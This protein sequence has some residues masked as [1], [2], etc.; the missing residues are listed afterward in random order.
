D[1]LLMN[2]KWILVFLVTCLLSCK[3][4]HQGTMLP[5]ASGVPI[6][7]T[8]DQNHPGNIIPE[9]FAG[10][11]YE[12]GILAESPEILN[13]NNKVL[14]QLIKNLGPGLLRIGGDSSD[15]TEWTGHERTSATGKDDLTT[16]DIDRLS[17]FSR[18]T[19]WPVLFGLNLGNNN[20]GAA[21]DEARY[22]YKALQNN[23]YALVLGNEPDVYHLFGLRTPAYGPDNFHGDWE[24]YRS[25][26]QSLVPRAAFAGPGTAY[27]TDWITAFA[28]NE[29]NN[30]IKL[31]DAHYY[32]T[33]PA[34][35]AT[36]THSTLLTSNWKLGNI[37]HVIRDESAKHQL[38]YRITES[39]SV[40]GG[41][42][43]GA[44]DVFASALWALD[45][46]W[47][48]AENE[49]RGINFH[50]GNKL[51]Y[52]PVTIENGVLTAR[53]LYYAMLAF[54]YGA[55]GGTM[56]PVKSDHS[57]YK[58]SSYACANTNGS[59]TVTLINK[60][61]VTDFAITIQLSK[62]VSRVKIDRLKAPGV[63]SKTGIMFAGSVVN[64]DGEFK[65][66]EGTQYAINGKSLVINLPAGSAAEVT[67]Q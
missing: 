8:V 13:E 18:A 3:K 20:A 47:T 60:E 14:V 67:V 36:I 19:G 40:Y 43:A 22:A 61:E 29:S 28:K 62:T 10:L 30:N 23:L 63:T 32:H 44:S 24:T 1:K 51:V 26:I 37:L 2:K 31:L 12:T 15:E 54:K 7:V 57:Q 55:V 42:K 64:A 16:S 5:V 46:M 17:A 49:G 34:S 35:D 58:C 48:I 56:L 53:P 38:P 21:A 27:N 39:N 59:Y 11:S 33:G 65:P 50:G 45:L 4:E 6:T 41:G 9:N 52:S 25:A 66:T